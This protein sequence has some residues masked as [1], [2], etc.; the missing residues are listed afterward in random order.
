MYM[1]IYIPMSCMHM[2]VY[3][4]TYIKT[5]KS[6][7]WF[8]EAK[9]GP[10]LRCVL[11]RNSAK[12]ARL[13]RIRRTTRSANATSI[14][15]LSILLG[16]RYISAESVSEQ[17]EAALMM[18]W[19]IKIALSKQQLHL[20]LTN[21]FVFCTSCATVLVVSYCCNML[22]FSPILHLQMLQPPENR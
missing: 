17:L 14:S 10:G 8:T 2:H 1:Y 12:M 21:K 6:D 15:P 4:Y 19:T 22:Q 11:G 5:W 16:A 13:G 18:G 7:T 9:F 20:V 3:I